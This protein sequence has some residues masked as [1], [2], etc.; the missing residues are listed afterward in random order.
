MAYRDTESLIMAS[1]TASIAPA[2]SVKAKGSGEAEILLYGDIG[3]SWF[4]GV[5]ARQFSDDLAAVGNV[6]TIHLRINSAGGD[7]FDGLAIYRRLVEHSA[8]IIVHV[9]SLAASIASVIA[10]AGDEIRIAEAAQIMIHNA[11]GFGI[12][13]ADDLRS[14]ADRLDVTT[15]SLRD[16]YVGRTGNTPAAIEGWMK[17]ET[18]FTAQE[19]VDHGFAGVIVENMRMAARID[20]TKHKFRN[21]PESLTAAPNLHALK[22]RLARMKAQMDRRRLNV[23]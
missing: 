13:E 21:V 12:G 1:G 6:S 16:V 23:A 18:W 11:W 3:D 20:V 5:T 14:V 22:Q 4:G 8:R 19:A 10:M 7:V 9:D 17:A 15:A 2:F